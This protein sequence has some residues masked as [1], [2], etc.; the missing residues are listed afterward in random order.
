MNTARQDI[1]KACHVG[2]PQSMKVKFKSQIDALSIVLGANDWW[3]QLS[4][5]M[6]GHYRNYD[7]PNL[8]QE[9]KNILSS[10]HQSYGQRISEITT[11]VEFINRINSQIETI[12]STIIPDIEK[13]QPQHKDTHIRKKLFWEEV[14]KKTYTIAIWCDNYSK[15]LQLQL[16]KLD[17][18]ISDYHRH[19]NKATNNT[20]HT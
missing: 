7:N 1:K 5:E 14:M 6:I 9:I 12:K 17:V 3:K 2:P 8:L 19:L 20:S 10:K 15:T 18:N 13:N 16:R 4:E 11:V